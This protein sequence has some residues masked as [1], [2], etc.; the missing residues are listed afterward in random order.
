MWDWPFAP[1]IKAQ[2]NSDAS[3]NIKIDVDKGT[4]IARVVSKSPAA[5]AGIKP[6]D[7]IQSVNGKAV[8]NSNEVQQAVETTKIGSSVKVQVRRNGQNITLDVT[9]IAAPAL[10]A[11]RE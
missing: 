2:I 9:P 1:P 4:L 11:E 10:T 8:Q 7:I 5:T 6:G 3:A